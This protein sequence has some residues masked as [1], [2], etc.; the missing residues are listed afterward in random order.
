MEQNA[1]FFQKCQK[2][3]INSRLRG[4]NSLGGRKTVSDSWIYTK[5]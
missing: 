4:E 2:I 5:Q 3:F 1:H